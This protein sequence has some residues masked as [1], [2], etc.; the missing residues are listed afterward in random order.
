MRADRHPALPRASRLWRG[1]RRAAAPRG[2]PLRAHDRESARG[3][4]GN[5][6]HGRAARTGEGGVHAR[7]TAARTRLG[8]RRVARRLHVRTTPRRSPPRLN[9]L[10]WLSAVDQLALLDRG[11]VS[12]AEL[13]DA[14]IE[15]CE[16]L[17][18]SLGF[19]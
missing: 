16:T 18:P 15:T 5:R 10:T 2:V 11:D 13:R 9:E 1:H 19:L 17:D 14:G 12:A 6:Q 4:D 7:G 8:Q 3:D